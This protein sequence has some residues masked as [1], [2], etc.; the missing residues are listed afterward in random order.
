[1]SIFNTSP[2]TKRTPYEEM[3]FNE[4]AKGYL[5]KS[6][7]NESLTP[8]ETN[9]LNE[10]H[11]TN[12]GGTT[13][14]GALANIYSEY[15]KPNN[16]L[17]LAAY[18]KEGLVPPR[19]NSQPNNLMSNPT[20]PTNVAAPLQQPTQTS[21]TSVYNKPKPKK[22]SYGLLRSSYGGGLQ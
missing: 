10:W 7:A 15:N 14:S 8:Q 17:N 12:S 16:P 19:T 21:I 20:T 9:T 13:V 11:K 3:M 22:L 5:Q 6:L 4:T 2:I 1:M 18:A